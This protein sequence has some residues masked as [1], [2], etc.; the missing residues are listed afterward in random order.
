MTLAST[1]N[2]LAG[3]AGPRDR[4]A[5]PPA[6]WPGLSRWAL[7]VLSGLLP[8]GPSGLSLPGSELL[9]LVARGLTTSCPQMFLNNPECP[10]HGPTKG[11][12]S[13][14]WCPGPRHP[15]CV[16]ET[17]R[18]GLA[19]Q[20]IGLACPLTAPHAQGSGCPKG[21]AGQWPGSPWVHQW[22]RR[23]LWSPGMTPSEGPPPS[24]DPS[25]RALLLADATPAQPSWSEAGVL[26]DPACGQHGGVPR[27]SSLKACRLASDREF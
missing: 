24:R 6:H 10:R 14:H 27:L 13:G 22:S 5:S 19:L 18:H 4:V 26:L 21:N 3:P 1:L 25:S 20:S 15:L 12:H 9:P 2:P 17:C 11:H 23:P 8:S 7:N 16:S